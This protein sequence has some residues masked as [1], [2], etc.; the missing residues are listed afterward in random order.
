MGGIF[1]C[2]SGL[3]GR[4]WV[5][6]PP[7]VRVASFDDGRI[8]PRVIAARFTVAGEGA[9][10]ANTPVVQDQV[11][12]EVKIVESGS[13]GVGLSRRKPP[14]ALKGHLG[15]N[16]TSWCFRS[17]AFDDIAVGQVIGCS[18]DCNQSPS[19]MDFYL[20]GELV[21]MPASAVACSWSFFG[22]V[23]SVFMFFVGFFVGFFMR[24]M[25]QCSHAAR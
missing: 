25:H 1:S 24:K 22:P 18:F 12:F 14:E 9:A 11:Y 3:I 13:V 19:R 8:G 7:A 23:F 17:D 15:D 21:C 2:V 20:D 5:T 16:K 10:L 6:A 4:I